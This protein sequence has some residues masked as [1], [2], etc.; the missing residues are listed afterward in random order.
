MRYFLKLLS[1]CSRS[2]RA[3]SFITTTFL[4]TFFWVALRSFSG[5][6]F[7]IFLLLKPGGR[8]GTGIN[9][10][11]F[12]GGRMIRG[13][14]REARAKSKQRFYIKIRIFVLVCYPP[15]IQVSPG[16]AASEEEP[17]PSFIR[18]LSQAPWG[19]SWGVPRLKRYN[20]S[21]VSRVCPGV[22]ILNTPLVLSMWMGSGSTLS[23]SHNF[24]ISDTSNMLI[25]LYCNQT[26]LH[27]SD[28]LLAFKVL[29]D[30]FLTAELSTVSA[31]ILLKDLQ[32]NSAHHHFMLYLNQ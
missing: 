12:Q 4:A 20:L 29:K 26:A 2:N 17:G 6:Q 11:V 9:N 1:S 19:G 32:E 14:L 21:S 5:R 13:A 8:F 22:S 25:W 23:S 18:P 15:L 31:G 3:L 24:I 27:L 28:Q 30:V 7:Q 10:F 16:A